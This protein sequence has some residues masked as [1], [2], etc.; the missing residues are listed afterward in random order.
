LFRLRW[1]RK[2]GH[3]V[4]AIVACRGQAHARFDDPN[5]VSHVGLALAMRL[6]ETTGLEKLAAQHVQVDVKAGANDGVKIG[7]LIAGMVAG[8]VWCSPNSRGSWE[9]AVAGRPLFSR[10]AWC[11]GCLSCCPPRPRLRLITAGAGSAA[12]AFCATVSDL[13]R[14]MKRWSTAALRLSGVVST[15]ATNLAARLPTASR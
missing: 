10:R 11:C 9:S 2:K 8:A 1:C 12:G 4:S 14:V 5:L 3:F 13:G 7:S 15:A 6:A